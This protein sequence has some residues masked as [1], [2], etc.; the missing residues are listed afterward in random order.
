LIV[1]RR[2][3]PLQLGLMPEKTCV[4]LEATVRANASCRRPPDARGGPSP[5]RRERSAGRGQNA[6]EMRPFRPPL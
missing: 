2:F 3:R 4:E 6:E 1:K 5:P